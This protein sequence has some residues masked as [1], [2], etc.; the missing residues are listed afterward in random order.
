MTL[1]DI[2]D[3]DLLVIAVILLLVILLTRWGPWR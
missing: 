3:H 2:T 1:A